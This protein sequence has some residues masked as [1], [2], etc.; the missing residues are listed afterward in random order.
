MKVEVRTRDISE[1]NLIMEMAIDIVGVGDEGCV[2]KL[3]LYNKALELKKSIL[4][5]GFKFRY[6]TPKIPEE[7]FESVLETIKL[8]VEDGR[9]FYLTVNDIGLL[10][11]CNER[12]ILPNHVTIGRSLSRSFEDCPW[13]KHIL[14][15]E[16]K[17][18]KKAILQNNMAH[19]IKIN[20]FKKYNV[21][22]IESNILENQKEAFKNIKNNGLDIDVHYEFIAI[23][24]SRVCQTAKYLK[25][26]IP[27]CSQACKSKIDIELKKVWYRK[28]GKDPCNQKLSEELKKINPCFSLLGNVLYRKS[29]LKF[30]QYDLENVDLLIL[31]TWQFEDLKNIEELIYNL[32]GN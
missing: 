19:K 8:L 20:F 7:H 4:A 11:A 23:A 13:Y 16:D 32:R 5:N 2:L 15:N 30:C 22:S 3:P 17:F 6:I 28:N 10:D 18:M 21:K 1:I 26:S 25:A 9:N 24:F 29:K 12:N 27:E 31:N 14:R